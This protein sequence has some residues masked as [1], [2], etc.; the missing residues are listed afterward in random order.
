MEFLNQLNPQQ[1]LA[2]ETTEGALLLLA[3]A[4]SGKTRVVT[5]RIIYLIEQ[6][7]YPSQILGLTFT[8]K[9]AKEMRDRVKE[10]TNHNVLISTFHSLGARMLR[11]HIHLLGYSRDF[12][13]YDDDDINK[14]LKA[15]LNE[16]GYSDEKEKLKEVRSYIS[17]MKNGWAHKKVHSLQ[18]IYEFYQEK[19]KYYNA[20][21]FDDLLALPTK[22]LKEF[23]E[24]RK[25]Y[26]Q[27]WK[28]LHIDEYQDTNNTQY[29]LVQLLVG[30]NP[31]ICVVGDPDQSIYSWR[32]A[33]IQNIMNFESDYPSAKVILLEENY[34]SKGNILAGANSLICCNK[35]RYEKQLWTSKGS[36]EKIKY[37]VG[38]D[39][40]QEAAFVAER[41]KSYHLNKN[42]PWN[43]M[44][45]FYR[46]HALSRGLEDIF[47]MAR[48][49]Y[50]IVEGLSF[51]QRRE[52]KD[53]LAFL[54][55]IV[56]DS[57]F[58]AFE[59]TLNLPKRGIGE[60]TLEKIRIEAANLH[61]PI[62]AYTKAL[63]EE[64]LEKT[65]LKLTAKQ[66]K[67]LRDYICILDMLRA[68]PRDN[69][70]SLVE[71]AI[72]ITGY[73]SYIKLDKETYDDRKSN[74]TALI[75][76]AEEWQQTAEELSLEIFLEE[77]SLRSN[78]DD[79]GE[80]ERVQLMTIHN[81]KGLEYDV[82]FIVGMEEGIMPHVNSLDNEQQIEEERR[83]CYV[84]M[85]RAREYL[86][87]SMV[88]E[89]FLW[90][91]RQRRSSSRFRLEIDNRYIENVR[92]EQKSS[93]SIAKPEVVRYLP[94][95][96]KEKLSQEIFK[97]GDRIKHAT[98]GAGV[99][100]ELG[101]SAVGETYKVLFD[102]DSHMRTLVAKFAHLKRI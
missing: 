2:V 41:L 50:T 92:T 86:H 55:M 29:K 38:K 30:E 89:R 69:I 11:E 93:V 84:A 95:E 10:M 40:R 26:Q 8:N 87:L 27:R 96:E 16:M 91:A 63:V 17:M 31:Q 75:A 47:Q 70:F 71:E 23:P 37:F 94:K 49:P 65:S 25:I 34:R 77:L 1:K 99:I 88:N 53:T 12:A 33:N 13:I 76:K 19:L 72:N 101:S 39:E 64:S 66:K 59:R 44:V 81:G 43:E 6:G 4:G 90:G 78:L 74:L 83:L 36:G 62:V 24:V 14:L 58:I 9:A 35:N 20:V 57:D 68:I 67:G 46:T 3:G 51:Y 85:T 98:F 15:C 52:I 22:L 80:L 102:K 18:E 97:S 42:V 28:Y 100:Q 73:L 82:V 60:T 79:T 56:S 7:V 21:D 48:I 5:C 54:K 61:M 32:G 45:V